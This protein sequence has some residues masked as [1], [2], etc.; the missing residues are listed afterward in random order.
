[1]LRPPPRSTRTD[2]LFPYTMLF[3]SCV[4]LA[5]VQLHAQ[6]LVYEIPLRRDR[7]AMA[8]GA[9][10]PTTPTEQAGDDHRRD[11]NQRDKQQVD[12]A[13]A[14]GGGISGFHLMSST[15]VES[16]LRGL[17]LR[18]TASRITTAASAKANPWNA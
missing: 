6:L 2:T 3:R 9:G 10:L 5:L 15:L 11:K 7:L 1:M 13:L 16:D 18:C 12:T 4:R 8:L 14:H 17:R